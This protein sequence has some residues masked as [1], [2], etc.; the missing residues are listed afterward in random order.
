MNEMH[1]KLRRFF[2][3]CDASAAHAWNYWKQVPPLQKGDHLVSKAEAVIKTLTTGEGDLRQRCIELA[4]VAFAMAEDKKRVM[5]VTVPAIKNAPVTE[6]E[7]PSEDEQAEARERAR[8]HA[9]RGKTDD[10]P[11]LEDRPWYG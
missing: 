9:E 4:F 11:S 5:N 1:E 10:K 3:Q 7:A 8:W 6:R 2:E